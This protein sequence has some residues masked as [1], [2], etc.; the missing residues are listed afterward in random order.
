MTGRPLGQFPD[1]ADHATGTTSAPSVGFTPGTQDPALANFAVRQQFRDWLYRDALEVMNWGPGNTVPGQITLGPDCFSYDPVRRL[2]FFGGLHNV[3]HTL[4][5]LSCSYDGWNWTAIGN[6]TTPLPFRHSGGDTT[7]YY[8]QAVSDDGRYLTWLTSGASFLLP[9]YAFLNSNDGLAGWVASAN[10]PAGI[11][12][13]AFWAEPDN[14]FIAVGL[15]AGGTI[16]KAWSVDVDADTWDALDLPGAILS[17]TMFGAASPGDRIVASAAQLWR[18]S[19]VASAFKAVPVPWLALTALVRLPGS[20]VFAAIAD[21][22]LWASPNGVVWS[23]VVTGFEASGTLGGHVNG[24]GDA[25]VATFRVTNPDGTTTDALLVG[26]NALREWSLVQSP[27]ERADGAYPTF[28]IRPVGDSLV[29][30]NNA[31]PCSLRRSL[32][33]R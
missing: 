6:G 21:G 22:K 7:A 14:R 11:I 1:W 28:D 12:Q 32:G 3:D 16:L 29:M 10:Q 24:L 8:Q 5:I 19:S 9:S 20:G 27:Q 26:V 4:G 17:A 23:Q 13:H 31:T 25:V 30:L 18:T 15:S 33:V 2:W